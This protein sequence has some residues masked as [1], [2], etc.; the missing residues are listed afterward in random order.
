[1]STGRDRA[2][3]SGRAAKAA[4]SAS[5]GGQVTQPWLVNSSSTVFGAAN[6]GFDAGSCCGDP[7]GTAPAGATVKARARR[8]TH[9]ANLSAK[10]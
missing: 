7:R 9:A 5:A 8:Q 2:M 10:A 6:D 3:T 4:S 1:M